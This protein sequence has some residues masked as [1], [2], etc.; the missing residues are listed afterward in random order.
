MGVYDLPLVVPGCP[1]AFE[2]CSEVH[3]EC[4]F[5]TIQGDS[6]WNEMSPFLVDNSLKYGIMYVH[7]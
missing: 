1:Y 6:S 4:M 5:A 3:G 7:C 2:K